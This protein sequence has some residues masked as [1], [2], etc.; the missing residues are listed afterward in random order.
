MTTALNAIAF[1]AHTHTKHRFQNLYGQ[2][3]A[4]ALYRAWAHLNKQSAAGIDGVTTQ[5][6]EHRLPENI[7]M[8]A[9]Q[10]KSRQYRVDDIKR[11]YIPKANG[12]ERPLGLPSVADKVVQQ[13]VSE[14]L[15]SI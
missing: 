7:H 12:K 1:K 3:K 5:Q 10:L 2:L 8:L 13:S 9:Q 4:D 15:Q 6:F 11:V 14:L